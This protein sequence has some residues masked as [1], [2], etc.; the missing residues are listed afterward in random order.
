[1]SRHLWAGRRGH[2]RGLAAAIVAVTALG[3]AEA[4][5]ALVGNDLRALPDTVAHGE[6]VRIV[7]RDDD[8]NK[9]AELATATL[10]AP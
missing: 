8:V 2:V 7:Y 4:H 3:V 9:G 5:Q 6:P 10:L 1:M